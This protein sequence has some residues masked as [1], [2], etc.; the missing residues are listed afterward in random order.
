MITSSVRQ[1]IAGAAATLFGR[2]GAVTRLA[3]AYGL[4]RQSVYRQSDAVR[5]D[6]EAQAHRQEVLDLRQ[7]LEQALAQ[8]AALQRRLQDAVVVDPDRQAEFATTA[9]AE[10]VSLP[11]AR[12]LLHVLLRQRTPRV[13]TLGRWTQAAA[14]RSATLLPVLDE[15]TRPRVQQAVADEIFVRRQPILMVVEPD[16]LC[17]ISGR[18]VAHR[19]GVTGAEELARLPA[20][21]QVTKDGGNGLA[22]GLA[23]ANAH[24]QQHGQAPAV[25]QDDHFH[26]L[27]DGQRA[28]RISAGQT[29]RAVDRA[30]Q[31][32]NKE[33]KRRRGRRPGKGYG[34]G[35]AVAL[36]WPQAEAAYEHWCHQE[37]AWQQVTSAFTLFDASGHLQT[38]AQAEATVAAALPALTGKHWDKTRAALRRPQLWTYLDRAHQQVAALP[39]PAELRQAALRVEAARRRPGRTAGDSAAAATRA[40]VL[41][42]SVLLFRAGGAGAAAAAVRALL[43]GVWRASSSVEGINSVLRMQQARHRRLTQGLLDLKRLYWNCH[44]F[45][46]GQRKRQSPYGRLGVP[47]PD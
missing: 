12:R 3:G 25:E 5:V 23:L 46:T 15:H 35:S 10:G 41:V 7:Q 1:R 21:A 43:A 9:Q 14:Q 42:A 24:R 44:A 29:N 13:P 34:R 4:C 27:R 38:R 37:Q 47:L 19:D 32:D 26:V 40:L 2:Y 20:L 45:R 22:K 17:W 30:W 33:R 11:A 6:L 16:S 31:A 8:A 18:R 28:L 36:R 39:V